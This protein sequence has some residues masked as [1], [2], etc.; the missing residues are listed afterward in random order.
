[1]R[2]KL[3]DIH[4]VCFFIFSSIVLFVIY[5]AMSIPIL[6]YLKALLF[7]FLSSSLLLVLFKLC[8]AN[9]WRFRYVYPLIPIGGYVAFIPALIYMANPYQEEVSGTQLKFLGDDVFHIVALLFLLIVGY[10][11]AFIVRRK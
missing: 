6:V 7:F 10:S 1:M 3:N 8:Y 2:N 9:S 11:L 5:G 4:F